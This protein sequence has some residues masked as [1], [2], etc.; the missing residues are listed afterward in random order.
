MYLNFGYFNDYNIN[1]NNNKLNIACVAENIVGEDEQTVVL[2]VLSERD[3]P[4]KFPLI[5]I[6]NPKSVEPD[7][8]FKIEC[9]ITH[10]YQT[11]AIKWFQSNK[12]IDFDNEK[13]FTNY[14]RIDDGK[15][16]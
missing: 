9:N 2:T 13:Y 14:S 12:P 16:N 5:S 7:S 6:T 4:K 8:L 1:Q 11:N 3:R 15:Y 10:L